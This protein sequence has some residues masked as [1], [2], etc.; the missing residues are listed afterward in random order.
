MKEFSII[1]NNK[2]YTTDVTPLMNERDIIE[3][4]LSS[5]SNRYL[6]PNFRN[7][8]KNINNIH[9]LLNNKSWNY[10]KIKQQKI[11]NHIFKKIIKVKSNIDNTQHYYEFTLKRQ[12]DF[13]KNKPLYDNQFN[14]YLKLYW[15]ITDIKYIKLKKK[16]AKK[17]PKLKIFQIM[18]LI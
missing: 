7:K 14:T 6:A 15:R 17:I 18:N 5:F 13:K 2:K 1:L 11:N 8:I 4:F 12:F 3:Y 9:H 16:I 10:S